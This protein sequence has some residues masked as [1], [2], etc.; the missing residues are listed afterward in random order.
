MK[1]CLD[2]VPCFY[3]QAIE[4]SRRAGFSEKKVKQ[5]IDKTGK[6]ISEMN[7]EKSPPEI[8]GMI[9]RF[10][11]KKSLS[12][13]VYAD[14]KRKSNDLALSVY[15][16]CR[17]IINDSADPLLAAVEFAIA[18][19]IIDY[20]A[21]Y[22][23]DLEK[24]ISDII[25][26]Q[27]DRICNGNQKYFAY[28]EFKESLISS[29][30]ILYLGDNAGETVFDRILMETIR[31]EFPEIKIV[32]VVKE[33]PVVN[34][35]VLSDAL[36]CGLDSVAE[37][38]SSGSDI[39]GTVLNKCSKQF[40]NHYHSADMIISKGQGNFESFAAPDKKVFYLFMAQCVMVA[41]DVGC[42]IGTLNLFCPAADKG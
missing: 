27:D 3:R 11:L 1:T 30:K 4:T 31:A 26:R 36:Y 19:N 9:N 38:V 16:E 35:A 24:D 6:I 25:N 14:A 13:D 34:D 32:Y 5:V 22:N 18:G 33:K 7:L 17:K 40:M 29:R 12:S 10:I 39:Q 20:S 8:A 37:I 15:D 2:C 28:S 21:R 23:I 42:D 41:R